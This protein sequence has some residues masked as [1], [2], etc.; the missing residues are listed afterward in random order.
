MVLGTS[1]RLI[2][3]E[4]VVERT[5]PHPVAPL[6]VIQ[7]RPF[8]DTPITPFAEHISD[9]AL[10]AVY[11]R[12][13][14]PSPVPTNGPLERIVEWPTPGVRPTRLSVLAVGLE[15][16]LIL[17]RGN[18][19][20]DSAGVERWGTLRV[21]LVITRNGLRLL[22]LRPVEA[23]ADGEGGTPPPGLEGLD[24][25][26]RDLIAHLRS[27][28]LSAYEF[29]EADRSLLSN[30]TVWTEVLR[31]RPSHGRL[32]DV[33]AMVADLPDAP[34]AYNLDDIGVLVRDPDGRLYSLSLEMD[35]HQGSFV[36]TDSPLVDVRRLWPQ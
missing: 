15:V 4:P 11:G 5:S 25:V 29:N 36:L 21:M 14:P 7:G 26:A 12:A 34:L 9:L 23:T 6:P 17:K 27:S 3:P 28:D 35:P 13:L 24:R 30:D 33:A 2:E 16:D 22:S 1:G 10:A 32:R 8:A 20:V 18:P 19:T 31:D